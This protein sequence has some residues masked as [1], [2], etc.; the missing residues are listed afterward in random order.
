MGLLDS[1]PDDWLLRR[2]GAAAIDSAVRSG[3]AGGWD[4]HGFKNALSMP[5]REPATEM[6][7]SRSAEP[8]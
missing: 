5:R 7:G 8:G 3:F 4:G 2:A 6:L 1:T